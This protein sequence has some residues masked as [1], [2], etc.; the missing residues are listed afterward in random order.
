MSDAMH[1]P[2]ALRLLENRAWVR[3]LARRLLADENDVDDVEQETWAAALRSGPDEPRALR[4]WLGVVASRFALQRLRRRTRRARLEE[5][6][7]GPE[8][9]ERSPADVLAEADAHGHVVKAVLALE[10]PYRTTVLLR[11]FEGLAIA[12]VARRMDVPLETVRTRLRRAHERLR[13]S[14]EDENKRALASLLAP[15]AADDGAP[16]N[17]PARARAPR[18]MFVR[19]AVPTAA[20]VAAVAVATWWFVSHDDAV[21]PASPPTAAPQT[22]SAPRPNTGRPPRNAA[23]VAR[24]A[25]PPNAPSAAT[26]SVDA[27]AAASAEPSP[28]TARDLADGRPLANFALRVRT[29]DGES[30]V[31]TDATGRVPVDRAAVREVAAAESGVWK[32]VRNANTAI[33]LKDEPALWFWRERAVVACVSSVDPAVP[34]DPASI[35]F[36]WTLPD[37]GAGVLNEPGRPHVGPGEY[38]FDQWGGTRAD[39]RIDADGRYAGR[40][41]AVS[42]A[43]LTVEAPGFAAAARPLAWTSDAACAVSFEL[44]SIV[45]VSGRVVDETGRPIARQSVRLEA[46][47]QTE[48]EEE[49][50]RLRAERS[51]RGSGGNSWSW[52][53]KSFVRVE[54]FEDETRTDADGLFRIEAAP[55]GPAVLYAQRDG[56]ALGRVEIDAL[57]KDASNVELRLAHSDVG[58]VFRA[59]GAPMKSSTFVFQ[60]ADAREDGFRLTSDADGRVAAGWLQ[61][62]RWYCVCRQE[63]TEFRYVQWAGQT[64]LDWDKLSKNR[65]RDK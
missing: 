31:S 34:L 47:F 10:E 51:R 26:P 17:A 40:V 59:G 16:P 12:D 48:S 30:A 35:V 44:R 20:S 9:V 27:L 54:R 36:T 42:G 28:W 22:A 14:L 5:S 49:Y 55:A 52:D 37:F 7:A 33:P 58:V 65:P 41:A 53:G 18:R 62:G 19:V 4:A 64:E 29:A 45:H 3:A 25:V 8:R 11:Y 60:V 15:F 1:P 32:F 57:D 13:E 21:A 38:G 24:D 63:P 6:A 50:G 2:D 61:P 43:M 23:A 46:W 56:C 39:L